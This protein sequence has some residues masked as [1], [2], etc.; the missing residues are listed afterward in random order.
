MWGSQIL[1]ICDMQTTGASGR[2]YCLSHINV[3]GNVAEI[4]LKNNRV[5][6]SI[7]EAAAICGAKALGLCCVV[8]I[9]TE[10]LAGTI[11]CLACG[12]TKISGMRERERERESE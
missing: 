12:N 3:V 2:A 7:I 6:E 1:A 11:A 9:L 5:H 10:V 4:G 8:A